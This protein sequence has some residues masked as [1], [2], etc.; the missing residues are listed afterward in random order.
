[1][2]KTTIQY[3]S[4]VGAAAMGLALSIAPVTAQE[5]ATKVPTKK[6][7]VVKPGVKL[8]KPVKIAMVKVAGDLIDPINLYH[9]LAFDDL[10]IPR[11]FFFSKNWIVI[12]PTSQHHKTV[13]K[14][15][16]KDDQ[17]YL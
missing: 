5:A 9:N 13:S 1:M 11:S 8:P 7:D 3:T 15:E 16:L 12:G 17:L 2:K 6:E 4:L 14:L 10:V